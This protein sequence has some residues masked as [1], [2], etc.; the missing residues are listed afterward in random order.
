MGHQKDRAGSAPLG[1]HRTMHG[2]VVEWLGRRI[3]SGELSFGHRP[4]NEAELAAQL[5][6]SRGGVREAVKALAAKGLVEPRP[7]LGTRVLPRTEWN[8]MD[9]EVI[10]WHGPGSDP[11]F[12][13]DL[14]ELRSMVEP[15]AAELA[16]RRA[17]AEQLA[18][19]ESAYGAM[20]EHASRLP[21]AHEAFVE[22]DLLFHLSLLR[23]S[24][25]VLIEQLGRLLEP[26]L[27]HGLELSSHVPG[28][29]GASLPMHRAVLVAV[30]GGR[31][32]AASRAMRQLLAATSDAIGSEEAAPSPTDSGAVE[33]CG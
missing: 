1:R 12:V 31:P 33:R 18:A 4:P 11:A 10:D 14:F 3:V 5:R 22:A 30:R 19:L 17:T 26:S 2:R 29:V 32:I 28:G 7:R 20:T 6:V 16:A 15:G 27:R 8:L 13:G 25:N 9:R 21:D 24:G 23:A